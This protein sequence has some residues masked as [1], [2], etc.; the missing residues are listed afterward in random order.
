M[1]L[2]WSIQTELSAALRDRTLAPPSALCTIRGQRPERRLA[3]HRNNFYAALIEVL[4]KSFPVCRALA[5]D[6]LFPSMACAYIELYPPRSPVLLTYGDDLGAFIDTFA[7]TASI[8]CLGDMA[9]LEAACMRA[10]HAA[11]AEPLSTARLASLAPCDWTQARVRLHPSIEVVQ[12]RHPIVSAWSAHQEPDGLTPTDRCFA[13]DALLFRSD[14]G[15]QVRRLLPGGAAFLIAL[16][17]GRSLGAA[18]K[19][20]CAEPGFDCVA[21]LAMIFAERLI[22]E[23]HRSNQ[24][25]SSAGLLDTD[26]TRSEGHGPALS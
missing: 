11:D 24:L 25:C 22:V 8:P 5:G 16:M 12:S 6:A 19:M 14:A 4:G 3:V 7:P 10:Y 20:A 23:L 2:L 15:V 1:S 17:Q 21:S 13:E 9:R 26:R 18:R